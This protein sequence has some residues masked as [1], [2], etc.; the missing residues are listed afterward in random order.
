MNL[1]TDADLELVVAL[2]ASSPAAGARDIRY[3]DKVG[4]N[5]VNQTG[6]NNPFNSFVS[7]RANPVFTDRDGD[8]DA[9]LIIGSS[10]GVLH[11]YKNNSGTFVKNSSLNAFRGLTTGAA[12][13]NFTF[14]NIDSD[15]ELELVGGENDGT[16]RYY[17]KGSNGLYTQKTGAE[18]P[19]DG[20]DIGDVS[21]PVFA[22]MDD[23]D[24]L[25]LALGGQGTHNNKNNRGHIDYYDK[26]DDGDY[27]E[28][29]GNNNPFNSIDVGWGISI[30]PKLVDLDGDNNLDL[31]ISTSSPYYEG[32]YPIMRRMTAV[33]LSKRQGIAM[34]LMD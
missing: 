7:S 13:V 12:G 28:K 20:I 8:G 26:D 14:V 5:Y 22:N 27:V 10:E 25:E 16:I 11:Y 3:Y 9:D 32:I 23:D 18:N 31:L 15:P 30:R 19:F 6:Q 2:Y 33:I 24:D 1:D 21:Y 4:G 17:D 34:H 29:T